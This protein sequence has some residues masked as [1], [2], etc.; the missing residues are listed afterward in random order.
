MPEIIDRRI[1]FNGGELSPWLDP[2]IDLAKYRSGCRQLQNMRPAIYGGAMRRPGTS[3]LGLAPTAS[4]KV[5]L[6]P[7]VAS[8]S[9]SYILEFSAL[10]LRIWTTGATPALV[11]APLVVVTPYLETELDGLQFAQQNDVLFIAHPDHAPRE[12]A[13][14]SSTD[15]RIGALQVFWPAT[16]EENITETTLNVSSFVS[17]PAA[18]W[19]IGTSYAVGARVSYSSKLW[20]A[21]EA[22]LGVAPGTGSLAARQWVETD[23]TPT[24]YTPSLGGVYAIGDTVIYSSKKWIALLANSH[25]SPKYPGIDL[26]YWAE[27]GESVGALVTL[28]ASDSLFDSSDVGSKWVVIHK[29]EDLKSEL[30][31]SASAG[32]YSPAIKVMGEWSAAVTAATGGTAGWETV[33]LVQ[34]SL[35]NITWETRN[36]I[37]SGYGDVQKLITGFEKDPC[38]L[39]LELDSKVTGV[40]SSL[41][42]YIEVGDPDSYEIYEI[43][44]YTSAT[45]V[46]AMVLHGECGNYGATK[47]WHKPAW[48]TPQ[49]FPRA[50]T[51]HQGRLFFGGTAS[52]PTTFWGSAVDG[53][54]DFRVAAE[55]DS[56]VSYTLN[57]DEASAVEW[58]VSQDQLVIGTASG[59]WVFG[60]KTGETTE[61]LR[62]NTS[63]GSLPVQ[64]RTIADALV[65]IQRSGRKMRE[66]AWSFERDGYNSV[67]LSMLAE[68]VGDS[69]FLQ[70]AIQRNPDPI[71]W[72]VTANGELLSLTYERSQKV[73]AWS[74]HTTDGDFESVAVI[75][76]SG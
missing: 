76:G 11:G 4:G 24:T 58:L 7:F 33:Y 17:S 25:A 66:F 53:Y 51:L 74:R 26:A 45:V 54:Q 49:G 9:T 1:S 32:D 15:W 38:F 46:T 39:R 21:K 28:T 42:C 14:Y 60:T 27:T 16:L 13:R 69:L 55:D 41:K 22:S 12:L 35:D 57:S 59:E 23:A 30:A 6:V 56:A 47:Y 61:K 44:G 29:R 63:Y 20:A 62:R 37:V 5:R 67:D 73:A 52:K 3:Y 31:G 2:R 71:V 75:P 36:V 10:K 43:T 50:V 40:P 34:R 19:N 64:A 70:M 65:F 8:V 68:H 72:V 18:A 48:S